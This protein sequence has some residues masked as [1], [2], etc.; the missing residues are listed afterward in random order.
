VSFA[1]EPLAVLVRAGIVDTPALEVAG[2]TELSRSHLVTAVHLADGRRLVVKQARPRPGE[3]MGTLWREAR[4]YRAASA[5]APLAAAVPAPLWIDPDERA[6]VLAAVQPGDGMRERAATTQRSAAT[7][8]A[9]WLGRLVAGWHTATGPHADGASDPPGDGTTALPV[10]TPWVLDCLEPRRW[11][12]PV[13]DALLVHGVVRREL[14]RHFAGLRSALRRSCLVHGDLKWD[15]V[16]SEGGQGVRV[17]DW[18]RAAM[19]DP[20]WDV[21]GILHEQVVDPRTAI[22]ASAFLDAYLQAADP[23]D[24]AGF[25]ERAARLAGARLVQSALE[26]AAA[27][28]VPG[29]WD[30]D[31]DSRRRAARLVDDALAVLRAPRSL[32]A[33]M[34]AG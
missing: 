6:L 30:D 9:A 10:E 11:R 7:G 13:A 4:V 1:R 25:A 5:S 12:P 2:T 19:G 8:P 23:P 33:G 32:L 17:V 18:E 16:V 31:A 21:A 28:E 22:F 15:N 20:A 24:P 27:A 3:A 29:P 14:R 26:H 34:R